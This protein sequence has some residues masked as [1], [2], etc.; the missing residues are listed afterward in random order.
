MEGRTSQSQN[1]FVRPAS[2][3]SFYSLNIQLLS[4]CSSASL[5]EV[6]PSLQSSWEV[7]QQRNMV[8]NIPVFL[9][10]ITVLATLPRGCWDLLLVETALKQQLFV[11]TRWFTRKPHAQKNE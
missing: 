10:S 6:I 8:F 4:L 5:K 9:L 11:I 7:L 3:L 1:M 2:P